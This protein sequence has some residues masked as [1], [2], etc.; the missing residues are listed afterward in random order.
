MSARLLGERAC[1]HVY[2]EEMWSK[3][4]WRLHC[5]F[6]GWTCDNVCAKRRHEWLSRMTFFNKR[7]LFKASP[8]PF[9]FCLFVSQNE[10][11]L[12]IRLSVE[13]TVVTCLQADGGKKKFPFDS[14]ISYSS[15]T[16]FSNKIKWQRFGGIRRLISKGSTSYVCWTESCSSRLRGVHDPLRSLAGENTKSSFPVSLRIPQIPKDSISLTRQPQSTH[17][18][19]LL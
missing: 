18:V 14:R 16:Y 11:F 5:S 17:K 3:P 12:L 19:L 15:F 13:T 8:S 7:L 1:T 9:S 6:C 10:T 4:S 2:L